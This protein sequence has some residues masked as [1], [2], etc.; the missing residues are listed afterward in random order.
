[1][2]WKGGSSMKKFK[3]RG[4]TY[5]WNYEQ[6]PLVMAAAGVAGTVMLASILFLGS[7]LCTMEPPFI[8]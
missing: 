3:F 2:K 6:S 8:A 5:I 4:K 1:M 7:V